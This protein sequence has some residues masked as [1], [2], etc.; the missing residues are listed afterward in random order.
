MGTRVRGGAGVPGGGPGAAAAPGGS[1]TAEGR[2]GANR[3]A[4]VRPC[5]AGACTHRGEHRNP[6]PPGR[7]APRGVLGP[8]CAGGTLWF[9]ESHGVS[10]GSLRVPRTAGDVWE[11]NRA[12]LPRRRESGTDNGSCG[13]RGAA[14]R[15]KKKQPTCPP[16]PPPAL[17]TVPRTAPR[18][19]DRSQCSP[20]AQGVLKSPSWNCLITPRG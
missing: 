7:A 14:A 9:P 12:A 13:H 16:Q 8:R 2:G 11:G 1:E 6:A 19:R 3:S 10:Q 20:W 4:R 17:S 15:R 5:R 18:C